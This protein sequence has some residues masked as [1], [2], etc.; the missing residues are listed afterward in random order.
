MLQMQ[1]FKPKTSSQ[2]SLPIH[3]QAS[4]SAPSNGLT[5]M[6]QLTTEEYAAVSGG[7]EMQVGDGS[8]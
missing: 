2:S 7:P 8:S 6:L 1:F 3:S 5:E 4:K